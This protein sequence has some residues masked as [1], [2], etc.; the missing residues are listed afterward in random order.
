MAEKSPAELISPLPWT[1]ERH[2]FGLWAVMDA[3]GVIVLEDLSRDEAEFIVRACNTNQSLIDA[4]QTIE[5]LICDTP[6]CGHFTAEEIRGQVHAALKL[7][8]VTHVEPS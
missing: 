1:V 6:L 3:S 7:A 8:G 5:A 4:L 2:Q